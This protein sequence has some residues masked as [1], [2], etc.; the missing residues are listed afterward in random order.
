MTEHYQTLGV[1]ENAT[2]EEIKKAYRKLANKNHPDKGGDAEVFK[3]IAAAYEVLGDEQKRAEYDNKSTFGNFGGHHFHQSEFDINDI[4]GQHFRGHH[5]FADMFGGGFRR[6]STRNKDLNLN[7]QVSF[8]DSFTGKQLEA[9]FTLPSG[10]AQSVV[11]DV[12]AGVSSG[13]TINYQ[14]LGDDSLSHLPRGNLHVTFVVAPDETF[15]R[16]GDDV[17][18]IVEINPIEAMIGCKKVIKSITG[19]D[20]S[21]DIRAG[22]ETGTE[23]AKQGA[24][25]KNIHNGRVGRFVSVVKIKTPII[26]NVDLIN[27]LIQLNKD[28][29]NI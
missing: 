15:D 28:I 13:D 19:E 5:P 26:K 21:I 3:K 4:F 2:Q 8:V 16:R 27:R 6:Q 14:G 22:V 11:I 23:F 1:D 18:T 24:G 17:Y 25:F 12:P 7:C 9:K 20:M 29:Q 10:K